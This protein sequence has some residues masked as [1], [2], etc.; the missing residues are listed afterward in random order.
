[1][2]HHRSNHCFQSKR[3][4]TIVI[5]H[6]YALKVTEQKIN[7]SRFHCFKIKLTKR[8][9]RPACTFTRPTCTFTRPTCTFTHPTK[10]CKFT[11]PTC[12]FTRPT[13]TFT[14]PTCTFTRPTKSCKFTHPTCKF[15]HSTCSFTRQKHFLNLFH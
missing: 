6:L 3:T 1:M 8:I 10:S 13:C 7:L 15:T 2:F 5:I 11:H 4:T 14:R 12:K 9:S